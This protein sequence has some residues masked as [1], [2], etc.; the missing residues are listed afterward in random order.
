MKTRFCLFRPQLTPATQYFTEAGTLF[1]VTRPED[2]LLVD[3][4]PNSVNHVF[5]KARVENFSRWD[6]YVE[7][8]EKC[9]SE[10]VHFHPGQGFS[11][12]LPFPFGFQCGFDKNNMAEYELV[13]QY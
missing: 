12:T 9:R 13:N 3:R 2:E 10:E 8:L 6:F 1:L 11:Y 7:I 4:G 5:W